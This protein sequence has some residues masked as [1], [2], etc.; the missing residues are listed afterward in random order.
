L[1][2]TGKSMIF[3]GKGLGL[4]K[5][6]TIPLI[7]GSTSVEI[8]NSGK[9]KDAQLLLVSTGKRKFQFKFPFATHESIL[10]FSNLLLND[11]PSVPGHPFSSFNLRDDDWADL[12]RGSRKVK[13][14]RS[15]VVVREGEPCTLYKILKGKCRVEKRTLEGKHIAQGLVVLIPQIQTVSKAL[16]TLVTCMK[17]NSLARWLSL[18]NPRLS[19]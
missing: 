11:Q 18:A 15:E 3:H 9:E 16:Y 6:E 12:I 8:V 10:A 14:A 2:V 1:H 5:K 4:S 19:P 17:A 13:L 7:A